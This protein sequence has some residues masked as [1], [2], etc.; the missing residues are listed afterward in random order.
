MVRVAAVLVVLARIAHATC[1]PHA[2]NTLPITRGPVAVDGV[3]D[4]ATWQAACFADDFEQKQPTYRAKPTQPVRVAVAIDGDTLYVGAR[5]WSAG[6]GDIDDALTQRDDTS[7]AERFIVSLDPTHT[8]R[9]AYSFAVTARGVRA[10][11]IHT[12]D[13]ESQRDSSWNPVWVA[14]SRILADGWSMEMAIPLSQLRLPREPATSWGIDFNWYVPHRQEDVFWRAVPRDRTAWASWFGELGDLPPIRPGL[15][16]EVLPYAA[17][18]MV[19]DESPTG[20][21]AHRW[22][23]GFEAGL[24]AKLRPLPGLTVAATI[25]PDFGQVDADPAFVNLTAYEVRLPER[26]PFFVE[27]NSLFA[28]SP[29]NYFYS[30]RIGGLPRALPAYDTI[31]LPPQVRIL[32]A[33]AAGGYVAEHTQIAALGAVTAD[34]TADAIVGGQ[35]TELTVA[36]LTGWAAARVEHQLG[37]SV[38]GATATTVQRALAGSGLAPLLPERA[39]VAGTDARLRSCD[40]QYELSTFTG[41]SGITGTAAAISGVEQSTAHLFQRP[42]QRYTHVDPHAHHLLG[43]HAGAIGS[44]RAG[45]WQ[46]SVF[47][48]AESPGFELNDAGVLMSADDIDASVDGR[49]LVTEPGRRLFAWSA[50]GGA[51]AEWNFGGLRKPVDVHA[52]ADTVTSSFASGSAAVHLYTPGGSDDLTRGGPRM[53]TGWASA[54]V[55]T[56]STPRGRANALSGYV[57]L[58]ASPTLQRGVIASASLTSRLTP[59]LRFD[60]APSLTLV[61]THRQYVATVDDAGGGDLTYG[62]RYLF[63]HLTRK[64][65]ALELRATWS[66]SPDLVMTL[67]AQPFVSVG[68]YAELGELV[69]AGSD[70]VRWYDTTSHDGATRTIRDAATAFAIAEPDYTAL[71]LRS[72]AVLRWELAPGSTLYVVWQQARGGSAGLSQPLHE[73]APDI[74]T[75]PAIHTLAVKLSYWFG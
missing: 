17:T 23:A 36:P 33:A 64:E 37:P 52:S 15:G 46:G 60:V 38:I 68:R 20:V 49:Y 16:V 28:S 54:A 41:I 55:L 32:G 29:V 67:Y 61:E 62:A 35:R 13:S 11:W 12:D 70:E 19:V 21:L 59:A 8:R 31:D 9:L 47:A 43:W 65:A 4:D 44:K 74:F 5:M 10:D 18:R 14:Q 48:G 7:G 2:A 30:R 53:Q 25:N 58:D 51:A 75:Q 45:A 24:D 6:A 27:N 39:Y 1:P 3:L 63:G 69:A 57:E 50:G 73:A 34:T 22:R 71:S 40:R 42:D 26:R 56:A 66:L 72:T